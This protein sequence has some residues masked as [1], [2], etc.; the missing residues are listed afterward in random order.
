MQP[1]RRSG[2]NQGGRYSKHDR[3]WTVFEIP[4]T[5][6]TLLPVGSDSCGPDGATTWSSLSARSAGGREL[7]AAARKRHG[8]GRRLRS[9]APLERAEHASGLAGRGRVGLRRR[10]P[11]SSEDSPP[12]ARTSSSPPARASYCS[13]FDRNTWRGPLESWCGLDNPSAQGSEQA[14]PCSSSWCGFRDGT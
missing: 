4:S 9:S 3:G 11:A 14:A 13:E 7:D 5:L 10:L 12:P 6:D 2:D 8:G 1:R